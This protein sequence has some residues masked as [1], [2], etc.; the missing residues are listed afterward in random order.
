MAEL[1]DAKRR[2]IERLKRVERSTAPELAAHFGLTDT[3]IRQHLD[4]IET[5]GLVERATASAPGR[6]RP[7]VWWRLTALAAD[8]FPDRHG[9]LTVELI[10]SIRESLGENALDLVIST[11]TAHQLAAYRSALPDPRTSSVAV[12][13]RRLAELRTTEGYLAEAVDDSDSD[14][15]FLVEHHCPICAAAATCQGLCSAEL[16][17]FRAALGPDA[18]VQ[19]EQHL[20]AGDSRCA[21][22][23]SP[24]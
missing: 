6:G 5:T 23:I 15:V 3:A 16:D 11:R 19:R 22:R 7:P 24:R 13:V 20:L 4:A 2:I 21:Y 10:S 8:L 14:D 1:T 9:D 12:R 18:V 17:L